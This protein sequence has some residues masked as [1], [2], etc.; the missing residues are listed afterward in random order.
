[1]GEVAKMG[2][3]IRCWGGGGLGRFSESVPTPDELNK[4]SSGARSTD[5]PP[6][7]PKMSFFKCVFARR[8]RS[9]CHP[10]VR[11]ERLRAPIVACELGF[12][13][14]K[15]A[16][17]MALLDRD[18]AEN[19]NGQGVHHRGYISF[20]PLDGPPIRKSVEG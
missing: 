6:K 3:S 7:F 20:H 17:L 16:M 14:N 5:Q 18:A 2:G 12:M 9:H 15:E 13:Y 19:E 4:I 1:M 8:R 10:I 11:Q